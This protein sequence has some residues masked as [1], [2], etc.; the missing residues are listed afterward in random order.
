MVVSLN[1]QQLAAVLSSARRF[2]CCH[3]F[4]GI[5]RDCCGRAPNW[6]RRLRRIPVLRPNPWFERFARG[7]S[8]SPAA[9]NNRLLEPKGRTEQGALEPTDARD[10]RSQ[11]E[12]D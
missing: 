11:H 10:F 9:A 5:A 4:G 1:E 3:N 8:L 2:S 12:C 7:R 6:F